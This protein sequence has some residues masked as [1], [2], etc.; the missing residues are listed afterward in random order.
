MRNAIL[1][2][3]FNAII[4]AL[5]NRERIK[6]YG[7]PSRSDALGENPFDVWERV[8][9]NIAD[10]LK[11][12]RKRKGR[13]QSEKSS[14]SKRDASFCGGNLPRIIMKN[15]PEPGVSVFRVIFLEVLPQSY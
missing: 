11:K 5:I 2:P 9:K 1:Q 3:L 4:T 7:K 8:R 15:C 6:E 13:R 10:F 14:F 12:Y